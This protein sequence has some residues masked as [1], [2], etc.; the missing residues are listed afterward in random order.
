M[1]GEARRPAARGRMAQ[2]NI[3]PR[4]RFGGVASAGFG[5]RC[6]QGADG[7]DL[8]SVEPGT[9]RLRAECEQGGRTDRGPLQSGP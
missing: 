2:G 8:V 3:V 5:L 1:R 7:L 4:A 6:A 9:K